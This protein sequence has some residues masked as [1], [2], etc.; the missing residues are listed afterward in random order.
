MKNIENLKDINYNKGCFFI[1]ESQF[2]TLQKIFDTLSNTNRFF[3][4]GD[5][6][7]DKL[8]FKNKCIYYQ[9]YHKDNI[10][11]AL[12]MNIDII[13]FYN[14]DFEDTFKIVEIIEKSHTVFLI[15]SSFDIDILNKNIS[16]N[17][18]YNLNPII[19]KKRLNNF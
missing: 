7:H 8:E 2:D 10:N 18:L 6:L 17:N 14:V 3:I 9:S 4:F 16:E 19:L 1:N 15:N 5:E 12:I 13:V 11:S